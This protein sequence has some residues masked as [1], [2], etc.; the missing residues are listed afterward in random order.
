MW[1]GALAEGVVVR[2]RRDLSGVCEQVVCDMC[3][4]RPTTPLERPGGHLPV[5]SVLGRK[6]GH[7]LSYCL[8]NVLAANETRR[9][10]ISG[11][12]RRWLA[13]SAP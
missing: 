12:G 9:D 7:H 11:H 1:R 4:R 8:F 13:V 6:H 3:S 2:S 10:M 5:S